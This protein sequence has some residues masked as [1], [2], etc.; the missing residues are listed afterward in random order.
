VNEMSIIDK[1]KAGDYETKLEYPRS[2]AEGDLRRLQNNVVLPSWEAEHNQAVAKLRAKVVEHKAAL[3]AY[4]ADCERLH[5]LFRSD[6]E[7]EHAMVGHHKADLLY[8]IASYGCNYD[9]RTIAYR[10]DDLVELAR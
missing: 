5:R 1:I 2:T 8:Q 10:Y 6:L 3:A 4:N 7:F 9:Y